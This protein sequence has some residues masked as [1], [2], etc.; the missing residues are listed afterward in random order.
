MSR[1]KNS[2]GINIDQEKGRFNNWD[3]P[4]IQEGKPTSNWV[5]QNIRGFRLEGIN[6][7]N[8]FN[9]DRFNAPN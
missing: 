2:K 6:F 3:Y 8:E 1:W 9:S 7:N 4:R 5:V